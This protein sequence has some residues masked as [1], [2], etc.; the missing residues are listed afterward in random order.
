MSPLS[1]PPNLQEGSR[2]QLACSISS[3]DLPI[4]FSWLKDGEPL[5]SSLNVSCALSYSL[6]LSPSSPSL[7]VP[8]LFPRGDIVPIYRADKFKK[9]LS[10]PR[11]SKINLKRPRIFHRR[12][13]VYRTAAGFFRCQDGENQQSVVKY[14]FDRARIIF[15]G[16]I[17]IFK[18]FFDSM[19]FKLLLRV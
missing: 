5:P 1:F 2:T 19:N 15:N 14:C 3:G 9:L 8:S 18:N 10:L 16:D 17:K 12:I 6:S 4:H 7:P 13:W 11:D